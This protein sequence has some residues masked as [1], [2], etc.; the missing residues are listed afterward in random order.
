[1]QTGI[2]RHKE[3]ASEVYQLQAD[4]DAWQ[5]DHPEEQMDVIGRDLDNLQA[6]LVDAGLASVADTLGMVEQEISPVLSRIQGLEAHAQASMSKF[7]QRVLAL[8]ANSMMGEGRD[9][10]QEELKEMQEKTQSPWETICGSAVTKGKD[11]VLYGLTQASLNGC[12]GTVVEWDDNCDQWTV[13]INGKNLL[14][15]TGNLLAGD[16]LMAKWTFVERGLL[17]DD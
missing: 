3:L 8:E 4:L 11:V 15:K 1:M 9:A 12:R 16:G 10:V 6:K 7:D 2:A 13:R 14:V 5:D 17:Q